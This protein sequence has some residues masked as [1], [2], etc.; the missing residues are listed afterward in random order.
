M[1][2]LFLHQNMPGQ[3]K[4]L[5]QH[6]AADRANQVVFVTRRP[7]IQLPNIT[8]VQYP[9]PRP[10]NEGTHH[11]LRSFENAILH[12]QQVA[13]V[14]LELKQKGFVPDVVVAH[15]GW[16][17]SLFVK[18][19][20]PD[21]P[22]LSFCEFY[23][24]AHGADTNFDPE[25][26]L[27][28]DD[29][30]RL[31]VRNS[32]L[33]HALTS[34]DRGLSPTEWQK[35]QHPAE[36][37]DKIS[38]VFDGIDTEAIRP[39][40]TVRFALPNGRVLT[41]DD[42]VVTYVSRNLEP[43]RG[44]HIFIRALPEILRR[45]PDAQVVLLGGDEVSYGRPPKEGGSWREVMLKEVPLDLSRVHFLGKVPYPRYL[46]LL[47]VSA[48]HV[49]LTV[50]FVLSWSM[51]EAMSAGCLII[52]SATPPVVEALEDGRNGLLVDYFSTS[53]VADRVVEALDDPARFAD[54][55]RRARETAIARYDVKDCLAGHLAL[56]NGLLPK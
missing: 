49:Y 15:P 1:R 53:A 25:F 37:R 55:R 12:G 38:V 4:H 26:P 44:F 7:D 27:E 46:D 22:V 23:Y 13:R 54:I 30:F 18:D 29:V 6:I 50:P 34:C 28:F 19:V 40:P 36:L 52:G 17:E 45:R 33:L 48:A 20:F 56:I 32:H 42:P 47:K 11:Y 8:K 9:P 10:V 3:F 39:D 2:V 5:A 41:R 16:G 21:A 24:R 14:A 31:R 35:A 43:Y 51:I